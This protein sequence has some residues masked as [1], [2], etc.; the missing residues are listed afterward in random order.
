MKKN[1][2]KTEFFKLNFIK[3]RSLRFI[4]QSAIIAAI[5]I[6]ITL[7]IA[8]ISSG[9][10]QLRV[11]EALTLLPCFTPAAIP[12]LFVGC[13]L[14][15]L[16]TGAF[17]LDIIF[18][19]LATLV[20]AILTYFIYKYINAPL[21]KWLAPLPPVIVNAFV[22]GWILF[23]VYDV[24]VPYWQCAVSVGIGQFLACYA[25]GLPFINLLEKHSAEI[26]R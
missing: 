14:A 9:L 26:F 22:V 4:V 5:Y 18:G 8:P 3:S 19:S 17:W 2:L 23:A 7:I 11:S 15:N 12:G 21:N 10:T 1:F 20:A 16:I 6:T 13:F 25:L 24:G